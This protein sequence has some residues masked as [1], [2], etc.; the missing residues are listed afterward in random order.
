MRKHIACLVPRT[1]TKKAYYDFPIFGPRNRIFYQVLP[2]VMNPPMLRGLYNDCPYIR[3][4]DSMYANELSSNSNPGNV[5]G[6]AIDTADIGGGDAG[7]TNTYLVNTNPIVTAAAGGGYVAASLGPQWSGGSGKDHG[8]LRIKGIRQDYTLVNTHNA[9]LY[10]EIIY[11]KAKG[12]RDGSYAVS[13]SKA[14]AGAAPFQNDGLEATNVLDNPIVFDYL[15]LKEEWGTAAYKRASDYTV[16]AGGGFYF[17]SIKIGGTTPSNTAGKGAGSTFG[18]DEAN[19]V[20]GTPIALVTYDKAYTASLSNY[21]IQHPVGLGFGASKIFRRHWTIYAKKVYKVKPGDHLKFSQVW[22]KHFTVPMQKIM[23][24]AE[25][26]GTDAVLGLHDKR[27]V[28]GLR[29]FTYAQQGEPNNT[30][31]SRTSVNVSCVTRVSC[32]RERAGS[33][34]EFQLIGDYSLA[35]LAQVPARGIM[36]VPATAANEAQEAGPG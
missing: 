21:S 27:L 33:G 7:T 30:G 13:G 16:S 17:N 32:A 31:L 4:T 10:L 8:Y 12:W 6:T 25:Y 19:P 1:I 24:A 15:G 22:K 26:G 29:G 35:D 9:P 23:S 14:E 11:I 3:E 28:L 18:T 2:H 36:Q 20:I 5:T 34:R